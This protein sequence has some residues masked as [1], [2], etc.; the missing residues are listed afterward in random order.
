MFFCVNVKA[1][2][3]QKYHFL[4]VIKRELCYNIT[5]YIMELYQIRKKKKKKQSMLAIV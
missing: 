2:V 3:K 5:I 4:Y 1:Q